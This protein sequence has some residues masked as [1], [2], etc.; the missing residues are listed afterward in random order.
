VRELTLLVLGSARN[1][2]FAR[3][4]RELRFEP[5]FLA[6]MEELLHALRHTRASAVLVDRDK[7]NADDLELVLNIRDLDDRV[8]IILIGS[9]GEAETEVLLRRQP[10]TILIHKAAGDNSLRQDLRPFLTA[11]T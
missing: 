5:T 11:S 6:S 3:I 9:P 2:A 10:A 1:R 4:L 8:P 7:G